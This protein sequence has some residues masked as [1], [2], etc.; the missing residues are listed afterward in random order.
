MAMPRVCLVEG[1][2]IAASPH[3]SKFY[4]P[5]NKELCSKWVDFTG[6]L[7]LLDYWEER[8]LQGKPLGKQC[9]ICAL[10]FREED[11]FDSR[12]IKLKRGV[13]PSLNGPP[14]IEEK[15]EIATYSHSAPIPSRSSSCSSTDALSRDTFC[16]IKVGYIELADL[17]DP[18]LPINSMKS[19]NSLIKNEIQTHLDSDVMR[20]ASV[21]TPCFSKRICLV[22]G[23]YST[24]KTKGVRLFCFPTE[25]EI[26]FSLDPSK[27]QSNQPCLGFSNILI[28]IPFHC[29][30]LL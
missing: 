23:C 24:N 28:V 29:N 20:N 19:R 10:H 18:C 30:P 9:R 7:S 1:C 3:I 2:Y 14:T 5:T 26:A 12:K 6:N 21:P 11:F 8:Q 4:F 13:I 22:E 27:S 16:P 15:P 25:K 17:N